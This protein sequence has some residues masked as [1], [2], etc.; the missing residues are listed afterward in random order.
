VPSTSR[1]DHYL[2]ICLQA[3]RFANGVCFDQIID[4]TARRSRVC[5]GRVRS[6]KGIVEVKL[7]KTGR[8]ATFVNRIA[9]L[10]VAPLSGSVALYL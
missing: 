4:E 10:E 9:V 6:K 1:I 7:G 3:G 2:S 8:P 5:V